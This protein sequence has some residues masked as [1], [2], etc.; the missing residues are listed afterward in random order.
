MASLTQWAWVSVNSRSWWWTGRPGMLQFMGLQRDRHDW[1][2]DLI[3]EGVW[4]GSQGCP[5]PF[6]P[7]RPSFVIC[8]PEG[9]EFSLF[10]FMS[11]MPHLVCDS[12][13]PSHSGWWI[14]VIHF[15]TSQKIAK[16]CN[17]K[18]YKIDVRVIKLKV[19][20]SYPTLC[21]PHGLY[22]PCNSPARILEW[23]AFPFS[24]GSP[25]PGIKPRSSA[26]QADSLPAEPQEKPKDNRRPRVIRLKTW[27]YSS[28]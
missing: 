16:S 8:A 4:T 23:I 15:P 24:R 14:N 11:S 22:S 2:T 3:G 9:Y 1:A 28:S 13:W 5:L 12:R 7:C 20:S 17:I 21:D 18:L 27:L 6:E 26:L 19:T 25:N 10:I